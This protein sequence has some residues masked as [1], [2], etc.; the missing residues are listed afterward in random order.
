[1]TIKSAGGDG[2]EVTTETMADRLRAVQTEGWR[3]MTYHGE[4]TDAAWAM[5]DETLVLRD[6]TSSGG[7]NTAQ[8]EQEDNNSSNSKDKGKGKEPAASTDVP[9]PSA[10]ALSRRFGGLR[11]DWGEEETLRAISGLRKDKDGVVVKVE[12]PAESKADAKAAETKKGK[13]GRAAGRKTA[14]GKASTAM[15]ID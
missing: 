9:G 1:M 2:D 8:P 10:E 5:Y 14:R 15:E 12:P 4:D 7:D 6:H 13:G 11:T 3:R